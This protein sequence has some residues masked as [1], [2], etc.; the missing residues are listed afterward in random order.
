MPKKKV[1][2]YQRVRSVFVGFRL[3]P[4]ESKALNE[5]VRLSGMTKRDYVASRCF[6]QEIT[7]IGNPRVHKALAETMMEIIRRLDSLSEDKKPVEPEFW[8][9]IET[10]AET[11]TGLSRPLGQRA[12]M[13]KG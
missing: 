8:E 5:R 11:M 13:K 7:V 4:E 2:R 12:Q 3:S 1:D 10:V 9:T 6:D